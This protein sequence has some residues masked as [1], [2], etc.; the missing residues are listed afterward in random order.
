[1]HQNRQGKLCSRS[2][3]VG[4][5]VHSCEHVLGSPPP[6]LLP[7]RRPRA[8]IIAAFRTGNA[9]LRKVVRRKFPTIGSL[10]V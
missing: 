8:T 6:I 1:M 9:D 5:Q 7:Q 4:F 3:P 10:S 2:D